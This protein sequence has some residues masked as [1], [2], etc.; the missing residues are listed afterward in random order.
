[1]SEFD[2]LLQKYGE[3]STEINGMREYLDHLEEDREA[4][5]KRLKALMRSGPKQEVPAADDQGSPSLESP[6]IETINAVRELGDS[7][8]ATQLAERLNISQDAA[9]LRLQRA[10]KKRLILRVKFGRYAAKPATPMP[11]SAANGT[12][13]M[14]KETKTEHEAA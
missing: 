9:R 12:K 5:R 8:S 11:R 4:V 2:N 10:A 13:P 6:M 3:I 14:E 1:M 7:V